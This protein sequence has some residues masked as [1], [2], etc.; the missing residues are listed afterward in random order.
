MNGNCNSIITDFVSSGS[1]KSVSHIWDEEDNYTITASAEDTFGNIGPFATYTV[2]IPRDKAINNPFL[3]WLQ[4]HPN[5][6]PFLQ[7]LLQQLGFGL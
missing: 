5:M 6:F 7:K 1:D 3:N 4:S 2:T